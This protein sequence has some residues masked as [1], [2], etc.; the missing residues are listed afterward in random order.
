MNDIV[1]RYVNDVVRRIPEKEREEVSKE[2]Y[3]NIDDML[4]PGADLPDVEAVLYELGAPG[5]LARQYRQN[6]RYLLSPYVYDDWLRTL[7]WVIPLV[8]CVFIA[9]GVILGIVELVS[10]GGNIDIKEILKILI[11]DS[12]RMGVEGGIQALIWTTVGFIIAE[13]AG[14]NSEKNFEN[15]KIEDLPAMPK[16]SNSKAL[17]IPL[18]D[19]I[20]ELIITILGHG[21][22]LYMCLSVVPPLI[23]TEHMDNIVVVD[24]FTEKFYAMCVPALCILAA[25]DIALCIMKIIFQEWKISICVVTIVS[26]LISLFTTIFIF[27][28]PLIFSNTF[29]DYFKEFSQWGTYDIMRFF[30]SDPARFFCTIIILIAVIAVTVSCFGA[31]R[32]LV[33][34]KK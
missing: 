32:K 12:I 22:L 26:N 16:N 18:S 15:W 11:R 3:A 8:A 24:I 31:I 17:R 5:L 14:Y 1:D 33:K 28:R 34:I 13:R 2:L 4:P 20:T 23:F 30:P 29:L 9:L 27:S 19:S 21:F 10:S 7:K 6:P 25:M